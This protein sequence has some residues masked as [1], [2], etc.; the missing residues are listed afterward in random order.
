MAK[1]WTKGLI[2][3]AVMALAVAAH[4]G[5]AMGIQAG[6]GSAPAADRAPA[7][8]ADILRDRSGYLSQYFTF[9]SLNP[10]VKAAIARANLAP[11]SFNEIVVHTRDT[12]TMPDQQQRPST[13]SGIVTMQNAGHGLVR[14]MQV[15]EDNG[16]EIGLSFNLTYRGY[17]PFLT[18]GVSVNSNDAPPIQVARKI[19]RLDTQSHGHI[20]FVYL[21]GNA[22]D[23][24]F[25]DP[26]QFLCDSGKTY[27]ASQLGPSI[28][29]QAREL[30]CRA[31]DNNG[32]VTDKVTL[33]YL[34][35]YG[36]ALTLR[37]SNDQRTV[38][39]T[40]LDFSVH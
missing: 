30:N 32:I 4:A 10:D 5:D 18:Q 11:V 27:P 15:V 8:R 34:E 28:G 36:V 25:Q 2:A 16:T 20:A 22:S 9:D 26:G 6:S 38:D 40:I 19:L 33:A 7:S 12:V 29:G 14:S 3:T 35:H 17:F 37:I 31:I 24:L 23:V 13:Y 21:Y 1:A 39:S